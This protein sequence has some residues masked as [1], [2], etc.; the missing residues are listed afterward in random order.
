MAGANRDRAA[1]RRTGDGGR[2]H[3]GR[4]L[5]P[6]PWTA[7]VIGALAATAAYGL[8]IAL[9]VGGAR[10]TSFVDDVAGVAAGAVAVASTA[11]RAR[12]ETAVGTRLG[13]LLLCA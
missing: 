11:L 13:W 7:V 5:G 4:R 3:A 1:E 10:T 2:A 6:W 8:W 9:H 12:R